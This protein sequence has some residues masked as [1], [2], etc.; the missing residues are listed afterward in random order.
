MTLFLEQLLYLY[1]SLNPKF[2]ARIELT[3]QT[4]S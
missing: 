2:A 3:K 1:F 4:L